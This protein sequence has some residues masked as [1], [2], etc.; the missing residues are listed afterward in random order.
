M[1]FSNDRFYFLFSLFLSFLSFYLKKWVKLAFFIGEILCSDAIAVYC[2][3]KDL[4]L[5][6]SC[7]LRA[8]W[9]L[10]P[11]SSSVSFG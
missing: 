9:L 10:A 6:R 2:V 4:Y 8:L 3:L 5:F 11:C 1:R 7:S